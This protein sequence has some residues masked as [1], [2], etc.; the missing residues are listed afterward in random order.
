MPKP[1]DGQK[2]D[3]ESYGP[4]KSEL[5]DPKLAKASGRHEAE[6]MK[7]NDC[8]DGFIRNAPFC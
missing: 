2:D 3:I 5:R 4:A 1:K 7:K 6:E 8:G